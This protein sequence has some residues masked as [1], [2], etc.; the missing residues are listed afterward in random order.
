MTQ[1][2]TYITKEE[3]NTLRYNA[4]GV[5]GKLNLCAQGLIPTT[6]WADE[7]FCRR[8]RISVFVWSTLVIKLHI[9]VSQGVHLTKQ[10]RLPH[11]PDVYSGYCQNTEF[12]SGNAVPSMTDNELKKKTK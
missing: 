11:A 12:S 7:Q 2:K 10:A 3:Q 8:V 4:L 9:L 6:F 5:T 1:S